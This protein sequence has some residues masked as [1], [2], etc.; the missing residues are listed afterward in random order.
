MKIGEN[1]LIGLYF[2]ILYLI[3]FLHLEYMDLNILRIIFL[4][5]IDF[6]EK[7]IITLTGR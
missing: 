7:S 5:Y 2:F 6:L 3:D 1:H 4:D